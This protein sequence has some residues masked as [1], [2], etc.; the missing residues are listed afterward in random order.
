VVSTMTLSPLTFSPSIVLSENRTQFGSVYNVSFPLPYSISGFLGTISISF[1]TLSCSSLSLVSS[2]SITNSACS[3]NSLIF[4]SS[5]VLPAGTFWISF[6]VQNYFSTRTN[7]LSIGLTSPFPHFFQIG[8]G[9]TGFSLVINNH[10]FAITNSIT[11]FAAKTS[12]NLVESSSVSISNTLNRFIT[13][14]LPKDIIISSNTTI[15]AVTP[16]IV[17]SYSVNLT[18]STITLNSTGP[19]NITID[20]IANPIKYN[21]SL[22]WTISA[23][24]PLGNPSS[25]SVSQQQP[26]YTSTSAFLNYTLT[27]TTIEA[28]TLISLTIIPALQ[29]FTPPNIIITFSDSLVLSCSNCTIIS[30]TSFFFPYIS[31]I[32]RIPVTIKNS[33][34]PLGN[35]ISLTITDGVITYETASIS[36]Q[37]TPM[38]YGFIAYQTGMYQSVG[39]V[40]ITITTR[41]TQALTLVY[42]DLSGVLSSP[43]CVTCTSTQLIFSGIVQYFQTFTVT[44]TGTYNGTIY[45]KASVPIIYICQA[46]Q[47]CN[48]CINQTSNLSTILICQQCFSNTLSPYYLLYNNQ[49]LQKCPISTYSNGLT[50]VAC[51]NLCYICTMYECQQCVNGYYIY[52]N[53]CVNACPAPLINNATHCIAVPIQCPNNCANCPSNNVCEAC[54]G[55]YYLLNNICYSSCPLRYIPSEAT[56]IPFT[57]PQETSYFPFPFII[58]SALIFIALVAMKRF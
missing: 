49:C 8:S 9:S 43:I 7:A 36:Y 57:P 2:I 26:M 48:I 27:D 24:D 58:S 37:L 40:N 55:G 21:G 30:S 46:I 54:D 20:N 4:S 53:T 10:S 22:L 18:S 44:L 13:I 34:N 42:S 39:N 11:T 32:M 52:D 29:Y 12:F 25:L 6:N 38:T 47:G 31:A 5:S 14:S 15:S 16:S 56:C 51:P 45:A 50:C 33:N 28:T 3:S 19:I 41:P 35:S 17:Y 23:A 1:G